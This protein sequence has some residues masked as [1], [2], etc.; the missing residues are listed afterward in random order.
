MAKFSF[1]SF[2]RFYESGFS[3]ILFIIDLS[4]CE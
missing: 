3:H 4:P 2:C 1:T